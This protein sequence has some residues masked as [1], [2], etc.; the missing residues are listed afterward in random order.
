MELCDLEL[1]FFKYGMLQIILDN[2]QVWQIKLNNIM[3]K[4]FP[5]QFSFHPS[6]NAKDK[7]CLELYIFNISLT[8]FFFSFFGKKSQTWSSELST[9]SAIFPL[10]SNII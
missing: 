4:L 7:F 1:Y 5:F 3:R 2:A 9:G 10:F 8:L 6:D